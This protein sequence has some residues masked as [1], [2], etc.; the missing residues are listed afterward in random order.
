MTNQKFIPT[1]GDYLKWY[2]LSLLK[3]LVPKWLRKKPRPPILY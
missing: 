3:R 1:H 2:L